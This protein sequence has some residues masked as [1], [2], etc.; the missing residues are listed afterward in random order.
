MKEITKL[1]P[2]SCFFD[3]LQNNRCQA[4]GCRKQQEEQGDGLTDKYS[5]IAIGYLQCLAHFQLEGGSRTKVR[6]M[7]V[8]G[9]PFF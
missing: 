8:V 5:Q 7:G 1:L 9:I 2:G 6:M 4:H 3:D